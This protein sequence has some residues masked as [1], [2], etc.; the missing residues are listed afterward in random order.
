MKH[1]TATLA[2]LIG[3]SLMTACIADPAANS[4]KNLPKSQAS[5]SATVTAPE[6]QDVASGEGLEGQNCSQE[7][8]LKS[9]QGA[10]TNINFKTSS[11]SKIN[12]YWLDFTGKRVE[13]KKG[14]AS[15][16]THAQ[17]TF[18]TH[19][20]VITNEQDQCMGIY[21]ASKTGT[22]TLDVKKIVTLSEGTSASAST[23]DV[24]KVNNGINCLKAKGKT[25]VATA[26]EVSLKLYLAAHEKGGLFE[27]AAQA[28]LK[29]ATDLLAESGC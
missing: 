18:V 13:Y 9:A 1:L 19:P 17:G 23:E 14:L 6:P 2:G 15:G 22:V 12:I 4:L 11:P 24:T 21:T 16:D 25:D 5:A 3:L 10:A 27:A 7:G 20:W 28:Y 29:Q 8:S 26:V